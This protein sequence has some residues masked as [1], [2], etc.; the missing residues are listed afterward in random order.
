[1][2]EVLR[3]KRAEVMAVIARHGARNPRLF[4]STARGQATA[5][6]DVDLLVDMEPGRTLVDLVGLEQDLTEMLGRVV[7]VVTDA[8]LSPHLR[9]RILAEAVAL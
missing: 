6:S 7:D 4:G 1:M 5:E 3:N 9:D 8:G 2:D